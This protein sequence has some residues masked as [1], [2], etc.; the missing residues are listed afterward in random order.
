MMNELMGAGDSMPLMK[1]M[2]ASLF[3]KEIMY[4]SLTEVHKKVWCDAEKCIDF[5]N[6]MVA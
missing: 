2:M 6:C 1:E 3:S 4:P 5:V